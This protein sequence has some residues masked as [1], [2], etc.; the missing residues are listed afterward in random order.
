MVRLRIRRHFRALGE[1]DVELGDRGRPHRSIQG[2]TSQGDGM[3]SPCHTARSG[4]FHVKHSARHATWA[5]FGNLGLYQA[6]GAAVAPPDA[7]HDRFPAP[8]QSVT[9]IAADNT[10]TKFATPHL[11]PSPR[12]ATRE[13]VETPRDRRVIVPTRPLPS[14]WSRQ[15][16]KRE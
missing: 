4:M 14:F 13:T 12:R 9:V 3:S 15:P 11:T 16:S 6:G 10:L 8:R 1:C 2:R 5:D 7:G